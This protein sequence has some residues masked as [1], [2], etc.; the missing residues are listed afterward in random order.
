MNLTDARE[1]I[2]LA[3]S[4]LAG[5]N[6]RARPPVKSPRPGDGWVVVRRLAPADFQ[7]SSATLI[8]VIVLGTDV[9]AAEELLD[10]LAV[11]M[12]DTAT[13]IFGLPT[14]DVTLETAELLLDGGGAALHAA[15]VTLTT[16]VE[17]T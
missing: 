12:I 16:E 11:P 9:A 15:T 10:Q 4:A 1:T 5:L 7:R 17:Q 3:L 6:V 2:A 13:M 14:A 8:A